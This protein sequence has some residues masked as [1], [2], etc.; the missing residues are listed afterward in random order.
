MKVK[1]YGQEHLKYTG[2]ISYTIRID[3]SRN[4]WK[5]GL[6]QKQEMYLVQTNRDVEARAA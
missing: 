2:I 3:V 6:I 5:I 1:S 4:I